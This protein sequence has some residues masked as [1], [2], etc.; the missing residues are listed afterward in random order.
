MLLDAGAPKAVSSCVG[1]RIDDELSQK[2]KNTVGKADQ[3]SELDKDLRDTVQG[4]LDECVSDEG[5]D[6]GSANSSSDEGDTSDTTEAG[7]STTTSAPG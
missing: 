1:N 4:I 3:L 2:Q 7:D 5:S 6:S